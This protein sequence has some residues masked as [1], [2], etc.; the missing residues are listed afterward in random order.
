MHEAGTALNGFLL[1]VSKKTKIFW[2]TN[3][4]TVPSD[5]IKVYVYVSAYH[6]SFFRHCIAFGAI[7]VE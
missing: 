1:K 7:I 5:Q 2:H 3:H 4:P 6:L